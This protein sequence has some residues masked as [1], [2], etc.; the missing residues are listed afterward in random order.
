MITKYSKQFIQNMVND[1][2]AHPKVL[3]NYDIIKDR[4]RGLTIGQLCIKY[5]LH[6]TTILDI[7]KND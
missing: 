2:V 5:D 4:Q 3:R 6:K 1:K 7:L